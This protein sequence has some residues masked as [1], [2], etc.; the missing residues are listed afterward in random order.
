M[1]W[2]RRSFAVA[3][4]AVAAVC[5]LLALPGVVGAARS[6][7]AQSGVTIHLLKVGAFYGY[8]FSSNPGQ[9]ANDRTVELFK[10]K[11]KS[12]NPGRDKAVSRT[13]SHTNNGRRYRWSVGYRPRPGKFYARIP[14]TRACQADNSKTIHLAERPNTKITDLSIAG[15]GGCGAHRCR[16]VLIDFKGHGGVPPYN[17]RCKRDHQ[18]YR[19]CPGSK[20]YGH[21]STGHHVFK[22][23]AIGANGKRDRTPAKVGFHVRPGTNSF[24]ELSAAI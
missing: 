19:S 20:F 16:G 1:Y 11:G 3:A 2:G 13:R 4:A 18:Q 7:A 17:Y 10:Q 21:L 15:Q 8:V 14:K 6:G 5:G 9:C 12:Q 23:F 24:A 22:V